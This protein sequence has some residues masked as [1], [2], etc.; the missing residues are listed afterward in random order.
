MLLSVVTISYN[1]GQYLR[2]CIESVLS[3]GGCEYEYII[4]DPGST[5]GSR[6]IITSYGGGVSQTIFEPDEGPAE[7]LNKGF[8]RATGDIFCY[9]NADDRLLPGAFQKVSG[10]FESHPEVD[11]VLGNGYQI[12]ATGERV[13]PLE[14]D[15]WNLKHFALGART[16]IQQ[17]T[18]FRRSA[19]ER[20]TGF[21]VENKTCWDGE[22]LVDMALTGARFGKIEA[23]LGEFRI[24]K[25]SIS[26]SGRLVERYRKDRARLRA[27]VMGGAAPSSD[28]LSAW[29]YRLWKRARRAG[30]ALFV[31]D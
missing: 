17:A 6:E 2:E 23:R 20:T 11:V 4:V 15:P 25:D 27:K 1:Q 16:A 19:Y 21:N 22:L 3:Q 30:R 10:Y 8:A 31:P 13:R 28:I 5:D 18:F 29:V 24:H 14:S 12:S 7:G 26:G 9:L